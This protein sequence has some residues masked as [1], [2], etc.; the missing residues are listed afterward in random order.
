MIAAF[1]FW[2]FVKNCISNQKDIFNICVI[3]S[4]IVLFTFP[5]IASFNSYYLPPPSFS[6]FLFHSIC[7][8]PISVIVFIPHWIK[9]KTTLI[10]REKFNEF[11]ANHSMTGGGFNAFLFS[12]EQEKNKI[13]AKKSESLH[14]KWWRFWGCFQR[15]WWMTKKGKEKEMDEITTLII[16]LFNS[17][18]ILFSSLFLLLLLLLFPTFSLKHLQALNGWASDCLHSVS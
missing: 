4:R 16:C 18:S 3:P 1:S 13:K 17:T 2:I 11:T 10:L 8:L 15:E 7:L 12:C 6:I 5:L 14:L 9:W